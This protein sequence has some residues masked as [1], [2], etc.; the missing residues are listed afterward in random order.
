MGSGKRL[1]RLLLAIGA[2]IGVSV[3][4][5]AASLLEQLGPLDQP[6]CW[7]RTYDAAHLAANPAQ[8]VRTLRF[9]SVPRRK[10]SRD[11]LARPREEAGAFVDA[12]YTDVNLVMR[13]GRR[14]GIELSCRWDAEAQHVSCGGESDA[15]VVEVRSEAGGR[16]RL[17]IPRGLR[18]GDEGAPTELR[19]RADRTYIL[20]PLPA[21]QCRKSEV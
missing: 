21:R 4:A 14:A 12:K 7:S 16:L 11:P 5:S 20:D 10:P 9:D 1:H 19:G 6:R 18:L 2:S 3:S 17:T 15:G 8:K 13:D